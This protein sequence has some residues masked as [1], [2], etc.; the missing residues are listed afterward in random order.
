MT[1]SDNMAISANV[2]GVW[3]NWR[4]IFSLDS[5]AQKILQFMDGWAIKIMEKIKNAH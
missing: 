5:M 3:E 4:I 2:N 1:F